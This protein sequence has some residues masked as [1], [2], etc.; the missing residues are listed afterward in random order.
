ML[1][2]VTLFHAGTTLDGS[3]LKTSGGRVIASTATAETLEKAIAKAYEGVKSIHFD[4][5]Q[6]RNDIGARALK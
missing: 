6:Y 5:M 3:V 1:T 2:D 4:G